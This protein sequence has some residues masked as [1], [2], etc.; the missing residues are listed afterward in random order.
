ME[1][2]E[3]KNKILFTALANILSTKGAEI[4]R[5][6]ELINGKFITI[7]TPYVGRGHYNGNE[8]FY[9]RASRDFF[10]VKPE[11]LEDSFPIN[12]DGYKFEFASFYEFEMDDDRTWSESIGFIVTKNNKNVLKVMHGKL[13][14]P[15]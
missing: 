3:R 5:D 11:I 15:G 14:Y 1:R 6:M 4:E 10:G 7:Q 8:G 12:I 9:F 2:F 13:G